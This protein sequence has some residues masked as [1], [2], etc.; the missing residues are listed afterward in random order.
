MAEACTAR[1]RDE[2]VPDADVGS[3][4]DVSPPGPGVGSAPLG[5]T[6]SVDTSALPGAA[7]QGADGANEDV[8]SGA[9]VSSLRPGLGSAPLRSSKEG[10]TMKSAQAQSTPHLEIEQCLPR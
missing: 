2:A 10:V 8:G 3:G 9:H 5:G 7:A 4:A 1:S 6:P